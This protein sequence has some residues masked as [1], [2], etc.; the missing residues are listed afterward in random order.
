MESLI[1]ITVF[2]LDKIAKN[3]LKLQ[4]LVKEKWVQTFSTFTLLAFKKVNSAVMLY[5]ELYANMLPITML[6]F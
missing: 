3:I 6:M 1:S 5:F 4:K 2:K